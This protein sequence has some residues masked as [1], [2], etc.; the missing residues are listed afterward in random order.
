MKSKDLKSETD[1]EILRQDALEW[2]E[3]CFSVMVELKKCKG[4][5]NVEDLN[6]D[7]IMEKM[8]RL[9]PESFS[10]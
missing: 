8:R 3:L 10:E 2:Q 4:G 1:I 5:V 7:E 6:L 9:F